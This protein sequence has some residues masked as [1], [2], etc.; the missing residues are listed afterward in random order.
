MTYQPHPHRYPYHYSASIID[1]FLDHYSRA[2]IFVA[3]K[4]HMDPREYRT[5]LIM[6]F[7]KQNTKWNVVRDLLKFVQNVRMWE[8][9]RGWT[10][11]HVIKYLTSVKYDCEDAI[12]FEKKHYNDI[13][14]TEF[15]VRI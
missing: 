9:P 13:D 15:N 3:K 2:T 6:L 4:L 8:H 5:H 10:D 11:E 7:M 14:N 1:A 12:L